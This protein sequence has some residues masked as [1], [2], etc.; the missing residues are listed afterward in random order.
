MSWYHFHF[1]T[2]NLWEVTNLHVSLE[3]R[4]LTRNQLR[5]GLNFLL[6][7]ILGNFPCILKCRECWECLS[8]FP[9]NLGLL[10]AFC[11]LS[12][13]VSFIPFFINVPCW[14][15]KEELSPS[16]RSGNTTILFHHDYKA[17]LL[18]QAGWPQ[19]DSLEIAMEI[20]THAFKDLIAVVIQSL[21]HVRF[22][23]T[24]WAAA[25]QASLS[26]TI[27]WSLLK[28]LSI[29]SV[30]PSNHLI[31]CRPLLLPPSI[32]PSIRVFSNESVI[33]ISWP[34]YWNF[35]FSFSPSN[36]YSGLI[37]FRTDWFGVSRI[38]SSTTMWK[39]QFF[40]VWSHSH[41]H[42]W[43]R[44]NHSFGSRPL[45]AK[46]CLWLLIH[47]LGLDC[48][49]REKHTEIHTHRQRDT[50]TERHRERDTNTMRET[51]T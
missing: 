9:P 19:S 30:M 42:T 23:A 29:E 31:L 25:R 16:L 22:F 32:F 27:S 48:T 35:S 28:L 6:L 33:H 18:Q 1:K 44:E 47:C 12:F 10:K 11:F 24:P 40:G 43:L 46:R 45:S 51:Y 50:Q 14:M 21:S 37:S 8:Y 5:A 15:S 49:E 2:R 34:K 36:E 38:F 13:E 41:I 20:R 3:A 17:S 39:H 7:Q 26:F 4:V